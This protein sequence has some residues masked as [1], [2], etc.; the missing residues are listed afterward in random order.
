MQIVW[1]LTGDR[2][3][4][5]YGSVKKS[6]MILPGQAS[7]TFSG[8]KLD[9][10]RLPAEDRT[11]WMN[12]LI[13]PRPRKLH[14]SKTGSHRS[15]NFSSSNSS[16]ESTDSSSKGRKR[17]YRPSISDPADTTSSGK[18]GWSD[19]PDTAIQVAEDNRQAYRPHRGT[20]RKSLKANIL[21]ANAYNTDLWTGKRSSALNPHQ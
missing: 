4:G 9:W 8:T 2:L 21:L 17:G 7:T 1:K 19:Q 11:P 3:G 20:E 13:W 10:W 18:S 14:M 12:S 16:R 15:C 5:I 6:C